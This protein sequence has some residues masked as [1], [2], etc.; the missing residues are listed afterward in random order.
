[1]A[2]QHSIDK[3][4][5]SPLAHN[6]PPYPPAD[7]HV[8]MMRASLPM[9]W[10]KCRRSRQRGRCRRHFGWRPVPLPRLR[11]SRAH[12]ALYPQGGKRSVLGAPGD[13]CPA[14]KGPRTSSF[15]RA[16][17]RTRASNTAR[18]DVRVGGPCRQ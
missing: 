12:R 8:V 13:V 18:A 3:A 15:A 4:I 2:D 16:L 6:S 10:R 5:A 11:R 9:A 1:M 14:A 7:S 17:C